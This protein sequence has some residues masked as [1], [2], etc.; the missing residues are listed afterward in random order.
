M[1]TDR[2]CGVL[3]VARTVLT[4]RLSSK[5]DITCTSRTSR[6]TFHLNQLLNSWNRRECGCHLVRNVSMDRFFPL[7][8]C[9]ARLILRNS[10]EE[11]VSIIVACVPTLGHLFRR[12]DA[13]VKSLRSRS[14]QSHHRSNQLPI[15]DDSK[16]DHA[17]H[18][19]GV[20]LTPPRAAVLNE[21]RP[22]SVP[23]NKKHCRDT[24]TGGVYGSQVD[25]VPVVQKTTRI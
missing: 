10:V 4:G 12:I 11:N 21:S 7:S 18:L 5:S 15:P 25:L 6:L 3:A 19:H 2:R 13:K 16:V 23:A 14:R 9:T 20:P 24:Y 22:P 8:L 17:I 1:L